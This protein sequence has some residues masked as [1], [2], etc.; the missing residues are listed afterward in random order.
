MPFFLFGARHRLPSSK[1]KDIEG[2]L[3]S[4]YETQEPQR[5]DDHVQDDGNV[6]GLLEDLREA[7]SDYRVRSS[8][9]HHSR[10]LQG[11]QMVRRAADYEQGC[12]AI[13]SSLPLRLS[14]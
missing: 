11:E 5:L 7:I 6:L 12:K 9:L 4:F 8:P 1:L 14:E 10:Y 3:R 13:V 2:K